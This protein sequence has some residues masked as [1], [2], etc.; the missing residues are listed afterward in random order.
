LDYIQGSP[1]P[2]EARKPLVSSANLDI[3]VEKKSN[4]EIHTLDKY[5]TFHREFRRLATRLAKEKR[6]SVDGLNREYERCIHPEL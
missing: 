2:G 3:F 5:A 1:L 6:V 4:Q